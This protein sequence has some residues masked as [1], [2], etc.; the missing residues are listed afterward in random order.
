MNQHDVSPKQQD[1]T[2]ADACS[3]NAYFGD[4]SSW[5]KPT[6]PVQAPALFFSSPSLD[7]N[8]NLSA[9]AAEENM[10]LYSFANNFLMASPPTSP[11]PELSDSD[12]VAIANMS[13]QLASAEAH[14]VSAPGTSLFLQSGDFPTTNLLMGYLDSPS[15]FTCGRNSFDTH[16]LDMSS[17][18]ESI[19]S[20]STSRNTSLAEA[21]RS[22]QSSG[23]RKSLDSPNFGP[24]LHSSG[25]FPLSNKSTA[26]M[27][28]THSQDSEHF[29]NSKSYSVHSAPSNSPASH[30]FRS[31]VAVS[32]SS[33]SK[34]TPE[35]TLAT[36]PT[37]DAWGNMLSGDMC[38]PH[39]A[40]AFSPSSDTSP[41]LSKDK[42]SQDNRCP[43]P[44]CAY[45]SQT[46][47]FRW[48]LR[49]HICNDHL[50]EYNNERNA[51]GKR[52]VDDMTMN[53]LAFVYVCPDSECLRA[54]YRR[55]SLRRHQRLIHT[56]QKKF[57]RPKEKSI[58]HHDG[59]GRRRLA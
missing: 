7:T 29:Y 4:P 39:D 52:D 24:P 47:K 5:M 10:N 17:V 20:N 37:A 46:F 32:D 48:L 22:R 34:R 51:Q 1:F 26:N 19:P 55:D 38:T 45:A 6:N 44:T 12:R 36:T 40:S 28:R 41:G 54:F 18:S 21:S 25:S 56:S 33:L 59:S 58:R 15:T 3:F 42:A 43:D 9:A 2:G 16:S 49:R 23:Y 35:G 14:A 27:R 57:S 13:Q 30:M 8:P 31:G 11:A 53:F 50:K